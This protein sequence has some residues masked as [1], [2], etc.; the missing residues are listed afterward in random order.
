MT[1]HIDIQTVSDDNNKSLFWSK[2]LKISGKQ[3]ITPLKALE[4]SK[5]RSDVS[6]NKNAF[7]F[8]EIYKGLNTERVEVLQKDTT[9]HDRF[10]REMSNLSRRGQ[11]SDLGICILKYASTK[12]T[13]PFPTVKEIELLTDVAHSYSDLTPIPILDA[14]IDDSNFANYMNYVKS[15]YLVIEELNQ[16]PIMGAL[17]NLPRELYPKLLDY[18]LDKDIHSFYFDFNGQT[19]DHLKLRPILRHLNSKKMLDKTFIYGVN[20]KP[21]R[22]LKNTNVIPSKDFIAYG[23]GLDVLGG[24]HIGLRLPK[25]FLEKM[26]KAIDAQQQNKKRIFIKSDY[27]YYRTNAK[28]DVVDVFP[29]DTNISLDNIINDTQKT[30]QNLFNME[31]QAVEASEIRKRL[32]ELKSSE[33]ILDYIKQKTQIQKEIKHLESGPKSIS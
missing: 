20:A 9:E 33:T 5:F 27:G 3:A 4:P 29:K 15:C 18:Y 13:N 7:G 21:G 31:Q 6:L 1:S 17:P 8:N 28:K 14:A 26:K 32:G 10:V 12:K 23:F 2:R 19:P 11:T 22:A 25:A 30:W 16:K 24:S